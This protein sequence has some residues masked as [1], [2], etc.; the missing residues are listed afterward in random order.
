M[1]HHDE[2]GYI[3]NPTNG[4]GIVRA[5]TLIG[6]LRMWDIP[7]SEQALDTVI[8]EIGQSPIPGLYM[9]FEEKSSKKVYI[10]QS[11]NIKNRLSSHI[12]NPEDKIKNW[13]RSIIISDGRNAT[14]SDLNDE[15]LRLTLEDHLVR[16]FK[17]NRY[18]VVT[19]SSRTPSLNAIQKILCDSLKNEIIILLLNRGKITKVITG[20]ADDEVDI[21][22]AKKILERG[23]HLIQQWGKLE[24]TVDDSRVFIR[25]GS[26]KPKG[27][28][29]TFRGEKPGSL[30]FSLLSGGGYLLMPRGPVL[31]VPLSEIKDL[32]QTVDTAAFARDTIDVFFR[33]DEDKIVMI[34]KTAER[35]VTKYAV[36]PYS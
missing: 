13:D 8:D 36:R 9:L 6:N 16:L 1:P 32:V 15:N 23:G 4:L 28:Q 33:F 27:W 34:Y 31:F 10:G 29:V 26:S 12:N 24:A 14:Q 19:S 30:K 21:A 5:R 25:P 22:E 11:E 35:D 18:E 3:S 20:R 2:Y 7:R 17:I